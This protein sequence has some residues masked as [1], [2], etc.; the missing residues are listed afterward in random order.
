MNTT[1][2]FGTG[3]RKF[4]TTDAGATYDVTADSL[5][6]TAAGTMTVKGATDGTNTSTINMANN[7]GFVVGEGA[8]VNLD[9]VNITGTKAENGSLINNTAGTANLNNVSVNRCLSHHQLYC[10]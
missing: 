3:E 10:L 5:G 1:T 4:V 2:N 9:T 6:A 8:T 7:T